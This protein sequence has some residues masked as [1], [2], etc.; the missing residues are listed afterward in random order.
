MVFYAQGWRLDITSFK[1]R[2]VG[3]IFVRSY[4]PDAKIYLNGKM[5]KN[6]SGIFRNGTLINNLFPKAYDIKLVSEGYHPW[7][8]NFSVSPSMVAEIKY[9]VL[10]PKKI[11]PAATGTIKNFWLFAGNILLQNQK[12][13]LFLGDVA[14]GSGEVIGFTIDFNDILI[15]DSD[16][17][18]YLRRE[19]NSGKSLNINRALK[20]LGYDSKKLK[21]ISIDPDGKGKMILRGAKE[22]FS[23]DPEKNSLLKLDDAKNNEEVGAAVANSKFYLSWTKFNP[24]ANS[25]TIIIYDKFLKDS[26]EKS[27]ELPGKNISLAWL[28]NNK[29]AVA[30]NDGALY[31]YDIAK[32]IPEKIADDIKSFTATDDGTKIAAL[33]NNALEIFSFN[34]DGNYY[35][36]NLPETNLISKVFWY[37]DAKHLFVQYPD[38]VSFLDLTDRALRNFVTVAETASSQYDPER[39]TLYFT[40]ENRLFDIAFPK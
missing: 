17:G 30:Q 3:A 1:L 37:S 26:R 27:F 13:R 6:D 2:K 14:I 29:M 4:P 32:N 15:F 12:N 40:R 11:S 18:L 35:R 25:S 39:N 22:I 33:E 31:L 28:K 9:A 8:E 38:R 23:F 36:F 34:Q 19:L 20:K 16:T 24:A 7:R 5:V 10:V 21:E